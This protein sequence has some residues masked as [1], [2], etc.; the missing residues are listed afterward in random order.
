ME[1]LEF[2]RLCDELSVVQA[3]LLIVGEDPS[4]MQAWVEQTDAEHRPAGY[5][6][7]HAALVH[8]ILAGRLPATIRRRAWERGWDEE[9]VEGKHRTRSA[10]A[11]PDYGDGESRRPFDIIYRA[12]P[13]WSLTT[14]RVDHLK[15]W[16]VERGF[17]EGFFFPEA[18]VAPDYLDPDHSC[19]APKLAAAV[20][21]WRA[22][23]SDP[24]LTRG[25]GPK[26]AM[27]I[28]LRKNA[29]RFGLTKDDGN[30]NELGIEEVAK[31]ANWDTRGG[32]PK[33]P[34]G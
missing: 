1:N 2:W 21:A 23:T 29:D 27:M 24:D 19:Y 3:A 7:A 28:W 18:T 14:V 32:A 33:T 6:A 26:Q 31:V 34:G 13:D 9:A 25:R 22:A 20:E 30:P 17:R 16:L 10:I 11:F 15:R 12:E 8:A 4:P 5:D